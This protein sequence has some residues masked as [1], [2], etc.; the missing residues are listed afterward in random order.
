M[1]KQETLNQAT[2]EVYTLHNI[3]LVYKLL[4][5][6]F[7]IYIHKRLKMSSRSSTSSLESLNKSSSTIYGLEPYMHEPTIS[8]KMNIYICYDSSEISSEDNS[9]KD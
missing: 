6:L 2:V 9:D 8:N 7:S 3:V 1:E 5:L 4:F